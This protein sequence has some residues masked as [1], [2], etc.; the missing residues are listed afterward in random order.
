MIYTLGHS[1]SLIRRGQF[2]LPGLATELAANAWDEMWVRGHLTPANYGTERFFSLDHCAVRNSI[3]EIDWPDSAGKQDA[4]VVEQLSNSRQRYEALDL[5][6]HDGRQ[7]DTCDL[8]K[9]I[10]GAMYC[11]RAMPVVATAVSQLVR[12]IHL[13]KAPHPDYDISHSD[14]DL[15]FSIFISLPGGHQVE[16]TVRL[17]ES[18]LHEAMHLQLSLF[19]QHTPLIARPEAQLYSPWKQTERPVQGI[20]H[21]LY[22]FGV[23][24]AF[25]EILE[26]MP[27]EYDGRLIRQRRGQIADEIAEVSELA[28]ASD[29]TETGA[30][31]REAILSRFPSAR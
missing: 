6:F 18:I 16:G 30:L 28:L 27:G 19:E 11:L 23:I 1:I 13:V 4:V 21:G 9:Q 22:V 25:M 26:Q 15:P 31:L 5:H 24:D 12:V 29:L 17:A 2:W 3:A 14:P 7:L 8:R 20:L 10:R